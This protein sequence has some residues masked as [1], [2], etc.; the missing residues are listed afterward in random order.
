MEDYADAATANGK[1]MEVQEILAIDLTG[2]HMESWTAAQ[3][4]NSLPKWFD[5]TK[6]VTNPVERVVGKNLFDYQR[7]PF[8]FSAT[9]MSFLEKGFN[10]KST[11]AGQFR[12]TQYK[13]DL[14][15]GSTYR[16]KAD[17]V[18]IT[19]TSG[20][21]VL[22]QN[23]TGTQT[24][25]G[26][27]NELNPNL[28]FTVPADG[29][30]NLSF[31]ATGTTTENGEVNFTNI[32]LELGT[33]ATAYEPYKESTL[34]LTDTLH[35]LPNGV[36]DEIRNAVLDGGVLKGL[37]KWERV[38][39]VAEYTLQ[40]AD[41]LGFAAL[42]NIDVVTITKQTD[43]VNYGA[44]LSE[45]DS[46]HFD[47]VMGFGYADNISN[48]GFVYSLNNINFGFIV[49]KGTYADLAAAK[50]ALAGT[51]L[52]YQLANPVITT[53][54]I[55]PLSGYANGTLYQD[56]VD[57]LPETQF[58]L[59]T[60]RAAQMDSNSR[61]VEKLSAVTDRKANMLHTHSIADV[62]GLQTALSGKANLNAAN[63]FTANQTIG[64]D[65]ILAFERQ[66]RKSVV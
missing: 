32:Q 8:F 41:I 3:I 47:G 42:T 28:Q 37:G 34:P 11:S 25:A 46:M 55:K 27:V 15:P 1:V 17:S 66:D 45:L 2:T 51:R 35:Q 26:A 54:Q 21:G 10:L 56:A 60:N 48:I 36:R 53:L 61:A 22:I 5:G 29:K 40:N 64:V 14:T 33:T 4:N 12:A 57:V 58:S 9:E 65:A 6:S 43:C 24:L 59:A 19:G 31:Y 52:I 49:A 38:Q 50:A 16:F 20:G 44:N 62:T 18:I 23:S 63:V 13:L 30:I 7:S 39:R